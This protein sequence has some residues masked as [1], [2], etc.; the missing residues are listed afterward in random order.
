MYESLVKGQKVDQAGVPESFRVLIKEFQALGLDIQI[1]NDKNEVLD[2]KEI[3]KEEIHE[4]TTFAI[5]DIEIRKLENDLNEE[6]S[7]EDEKD[8]TEE[9]EIEDKELQEEKLESEVKY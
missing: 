6:D 3:E 1:I 7:L 8:E 4:K 5:D 2:L 9:E